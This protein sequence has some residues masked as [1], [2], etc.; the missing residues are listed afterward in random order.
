MIGFI[1]GANTALLSN[2]IIGQG[3]WVLYQMFG[4]GLIGIIGGILNPKKESK[5]NR[6]VN[7]FIG[8]SLGFIYGWILNIWSWILFITPLTFKSFLLYNLSSIYMDLSHALTNAIFLYYFGNHTINILYRYRQRFLIEIHDFSLIENM[9]KDIHQ[10][11]YQIKNKTVVKN[12][13]SS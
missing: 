4:W 9:E 13:K 12:K 11:N 5:P 6:G 2:F 3:P 1:I 8:F 10:I 7:A